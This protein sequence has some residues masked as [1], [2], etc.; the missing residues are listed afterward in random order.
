M[1]APNPSQQPEPASDGKHA[2][3]S[4]NAPNTGQSSQDPVEGADDVDPPTE[5]SPRG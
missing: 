2:D 3:A 5:G 1:T 4:R